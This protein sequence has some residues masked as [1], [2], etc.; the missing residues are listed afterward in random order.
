MDVNF[1]LIKSP[2]DFHPNEGVQTDIYTVRHFGARTK[3]LILSGHVSM[4]VETLATTS[5]ETLRMLRTDS[6]VRES[7]VI[8]S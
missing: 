3:E 8:G 2:S 5:R 4:E 1:L 7:T 6:G